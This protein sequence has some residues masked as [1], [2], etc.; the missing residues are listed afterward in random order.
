MHMKSDGRIPRTFSY[1]LIE[2]GAFNTFSVTLSLDAELLTRLRDQD[3]AVYRIDVWVTAGDW[4]RVGK[5]AVIR[6]YLFSPQ[7]L[8]TVARAEDTTYDAGSPPTQ[9]AWSYDRVQYDLADELQDPADIE[10]GGG[11]FSLPSQDI[12]R[13][14]SS[15]PP[16]HFQH[17]TRTV[18]A[19]RR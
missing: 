14:P 2:L 16:G 9:L 5:S 10:L 13:R 17:S 3:V 1:H 18:N 4:P 15:R 19:R 12:E 8:P 6:V 7:Y 11:R